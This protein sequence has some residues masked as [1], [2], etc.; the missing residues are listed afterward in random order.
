MLQLMIVIVSKRNEPLVD[1]DVLTDL[2]SYP[3]SSTSV[4][5]TPFHQPIGY[6]YDLQR[7]KN[8]VHDSKK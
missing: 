8:H 6:R 1:N 5:F 3:Q 2:P 7:Q 4:S